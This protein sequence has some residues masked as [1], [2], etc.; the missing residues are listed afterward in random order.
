MAS[1]LEPSDVQSVKL[2]ITKLWNASGVGVSVSENDPNYLNP[3]EG[4]LQTKDAE[5]NLASGWMINW[6]TTKIYTPN[7]IVPD[8]SDATIAQKSADWTTV[9]AS[10]VSRFEPVPDPSQDPYASGVAYW[11]AVSVSL[12]EAPHPEDFHQ[13]DD[14][15]LTPV[16]T[17]VSGVVNYASGQGIYA[18]GVSTYASDAV[19]YGSGSVVYTSGVPSGYETDGVFKIAAIAYDT[20]GA[21]F[22][23]SD[24]V[25]VSNSG[26]NIQVANSGLPG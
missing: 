13:H 24:N 12:I 19:A 5:Y 16:R 2:N 18:T 26:S 6:D 15:D 7:V 9:Y 20:Q 14:H 25:R 11:G 17:L 21:K 4:S 22:Y 10:G 3:I 8:L 23:T 1:S